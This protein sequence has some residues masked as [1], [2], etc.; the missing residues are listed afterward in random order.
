MEILPQFG[1]VGRPWPPL[2][3]RSPKG[4]MDRASWL[5]VGE[6]RTLWFSWDPPG[7]EDPRAR[8][9]EQGITR[10]DHQYCG[11]ICLIQHMIYV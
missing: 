10:A 8:R 9:L 6:G 7:L 4:C 11:P 5:R 3:V 2:I 1:E